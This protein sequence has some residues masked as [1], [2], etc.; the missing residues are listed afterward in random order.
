MDDPERFQ[1]VTVFYPYRS[2]QKIRTFHDIS[3]MKFFTL[4]IFLVLLLLVSSARADW[5]NLTGGQ[6]SPN[7]AEIHVNDNH[8][9]VV[10][11]I[12]VGDVDK[13]VDLLLDAWV[14]QA[15]V[16]PPPIEERMR[17]F[18]TE[19]FRLWSRI[20]PGCRQSGR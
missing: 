6:S 19:T 7:I 16:E 17:R 9:R 15:G 14:R 8:I 4:I 2:N 5:I 12:Y 3:V 11:E 20:L 13:F 1:V 18:S 10:L